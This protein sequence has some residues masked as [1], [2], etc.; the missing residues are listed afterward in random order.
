MID[1]GK[2]SRCRWCGKKFTD[3]HQAY[4]GWNTNNL[5]NLDGHYFAHRICLDIFEDNDEDMIRFAIDTG[6][7]TQSKILSVNLKNI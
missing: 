6:F 5:G 3:T 1:E 7:L 4:F 2:E